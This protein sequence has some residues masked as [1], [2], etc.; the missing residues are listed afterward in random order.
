[1]DEASGG[2]GRKTQKPRALFLNGTIEKFVERSRRCELLPA[3]FGH[4]KMHS[5]RLAG[6]IGAV[7]INA[8]FF[9]RWSATPTWRRVDLRT[10][11]GNSRFGD[12]LLFGGLQSRRHPV[13]RT[14]A[15]TGE[16]VHDHPVRNHQS[17]SGPG[18]LDVAG[19]ADRRSQVL[20]RI[21]EDFHVPSLAG[22][23]YQP[24]AN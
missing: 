10:S 8:E 24:R 15:S 4:D 18:H 9:E 14:A 1:L 6:T 19:I 17:R 13:D 23:F 16:Y 21:S 2:F 22:I 11:G 5:S 7:L 12:A 3:D 20:Y